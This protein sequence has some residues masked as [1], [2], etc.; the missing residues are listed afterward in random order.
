M[1]RP[2]EF[3]DEQIIEA[4]QKLVSQNQRV[5]GFALRNLVGGGLPKR[6]MVVWTE[7][8]EKAAPAKKQDDDAPLE[9]GE[10]LDE[11]TGDFSTKLAGWAKQIYA[12][13]N[14]LADRRVAEV[15]RNSRE[16]AERIEAELSDAMAAVTTAEERA[17]EANMQLA[18]AHQDNAK[19]F[20]E[21]EQLKAARHSAEQALA[22]AEA[23]VGEL[24]SHIADLKAEASREREGFAQQLAELKELLATRNQLLDSKTEELGQVRESLARSEAQTQAFNE[25][26][27]DFRKRTAEEAARN[28]DRF[29]KLERELQEA[30]GQASNAA[31][32]AARWEGEANALRAEIG[33]LSA[34]Q[35][36]AKPAKPTSTKKDAGTPATE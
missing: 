8:L 9:L 33:R 6:L 27:A 29:L 7:H 18:N 35:T 31:Q 28:G 19:L 12:I 20:D 4:G 3:T 32:A 15:I 34:A 25:Q 21:A 10:I 5:T 36:A 1:A 23:R 16:E 17:D 26:F 13:A 14:K 2:T 24:T 30:N 11:I 22:A